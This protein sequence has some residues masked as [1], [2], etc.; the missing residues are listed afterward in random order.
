MGSEKGRMKMGK[1]FTN[2]QTIMEDIISQEL[3]DNESTLQ[4]K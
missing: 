2:V 1:N 4:R 3:A